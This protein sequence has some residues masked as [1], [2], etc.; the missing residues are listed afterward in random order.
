MR[1]ALSEGRITKWRELYH[2]LTPRDVAELNAYFQLEPWGE[3]RADMREAV[4]TSAIL[5]GQGHKIEPAELCKYLRD[6]EEKE[7]SPNAVAAMMRQKFP[8]RSR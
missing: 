1:I 5:A 7:Q 3:V 8:S 2:E 4:M 6:E